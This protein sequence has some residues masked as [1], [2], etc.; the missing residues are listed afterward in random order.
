MRRLRLQH[1][2][3]IFWKPADLDPWPPDLG[4]HPRPTNVQRELLLVHGGEL[5]LRLL[6]KPDG[7]GGL[8]DQGL[9][10]IDSGVRRR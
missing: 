9:V 3:S 6:S 2:A 4:V 10:A 5:L 1:D 7:D 8:V